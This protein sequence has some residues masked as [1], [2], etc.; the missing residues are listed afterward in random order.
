MENNW[1]G[2]SSDS[3]IQTTIYDFFDDFNLGIVDYT[4]FLTQPNTG[5][6]VS[7]PLG[8]AAVGNAASLAIALSWK[9][10]P[11]SDIAGYKVYYDTDGPG[12]PYSGDGSTSG[13]SP[14]DVGKVTSFTL[15]GLDLR[16]TYY[17][18][19]TAY[20]LDGNESWYSKEAVAV[21][22]PDVVG[23]LRLVAPVFD[24]TVNTGSPT[25]RWTRPA[26]LPFG[27]VTY[28]ARIVNALTVLGFTPFTADNFFVA[29]FNV[30]GDLRTTGP[31]CTG[32]TDTGDEIQIKVL[33][34]DGGALVPDGTHRLEV[35]VV[36][37]RGPH[38]RRCSQL[39][40]AGGQ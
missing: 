38:Q 30:T 5:A 22:S 29:C 39:P 13:S 36:D 25:F 15:S 7:P 18:A 14:V 8:L 16:R 40:A 4:P 28:E 3:D 2:T 1:W 26:E 27:L 10:N 32:A 21:L 33:K 37:T 12:F 6:P 35:R 19:V 34:V 11:E 31:G 23:N 20:D 17:I 9:A 24:N